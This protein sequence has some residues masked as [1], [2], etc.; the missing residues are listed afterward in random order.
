MTHSKFLKLLQDRDAAIECLR[1]IE[2]EPYEHD[3]DRVFL[4][5]RQEWMTLQ[6]LIA[7]AKFA[8]GVCTYD[9]TGDPQ[10][11]SPTGR[12]EESRPNLQNIPLSTPEGRKIREAFFGA[13]D[14]Q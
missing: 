12:I 8:A 7:V 10:P 11:V 3:P 4:E 13:M 2:H 6:E 5:G 9:E 1:Q 14:K